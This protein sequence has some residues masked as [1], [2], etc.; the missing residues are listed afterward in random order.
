MLSSTSEH[1]AVAFET[2]CV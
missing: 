2:S 1:I